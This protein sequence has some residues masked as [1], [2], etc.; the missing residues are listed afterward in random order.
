MMRFQTK[1]SLLLLGLTFSLV[2]GCES[3]QPIQQQPVVK[4]QER[5]IPTRIRPS[6]SGWWN[7]PDSSGAFGAVGQAKIVGSEGNAQGR[8]EIQAKAAL[9][10]SMEDTVQAITGSWI[11]QVS[12]AGNR[13]SFSSALNDKNFG[14]KLV[15]HNLQAARLSHREVVDGYVACLVSLKK[16]GKFLNNLQQGIDERAITSGS[17]FKGADQ[18][19]QARLALTKII[20]QARTEAQVEQER[21]VALIRTAELV[22]IKTDVDGPTPGTH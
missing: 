12:S 13:A 21:R 18:Q 9:A 10:V 22:S 11:E 3:T 4:V 6:I 16:P 1:P 14:H 5:A 17:Y 7:H 2:T 8:A 20:D 15:D 19:S